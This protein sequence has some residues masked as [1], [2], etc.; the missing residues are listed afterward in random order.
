MI[1]YIDSPVPYII[2]ISETVWNKIVMTKWNEAADDTV[3][4]Y[5]ETALLMSKLDMPNNPEPMA[6]TLI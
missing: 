2:G 1:D 6:S 4:F 3:A 5:I